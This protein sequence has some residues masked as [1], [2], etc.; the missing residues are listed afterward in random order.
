MGYLIKDK[1]T[2]D[3]NFRIVEDITKI[4]KIDLKKLSIFYY[5]EID[6]KYFEEEIKNHRKMELMKEIE[7]KNKELTE[8]GG[9][10][11]SNI[12]HSY[13][14]PMNPNIN[15]GGMVNNII[16][17]PSSIS[18]LAPTNDVLKLPNSQ[19]VEILFQ[20][21]RK[22]MESREEYN[23]VIY[24]EN[25]GT[26]FIAIVTEKNSRFPKNIRNVPI[27]QITEEEKQQIL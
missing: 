13:I 23:N 26:H 3:D 12:N 17:L 1:D 4:K 21:F 15:A 14:P 5:Y 19:E 22:D 27:L 18:S 6:S 20:Q 24:C 11:P 9:P 16:P 7:K 8:L 2:P 10:V 25:A